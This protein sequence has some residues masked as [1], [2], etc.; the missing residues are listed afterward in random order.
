MAA[1]PAAGRFASARLTR[2]LPLLAAPRGG[3]AAPGTGT[4]SA[5]RPSLAG[6]GC[7]WSWPARI[8]D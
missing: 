4:V 1:T 5:A 8:R 6:E 3:I 2:R 7:T